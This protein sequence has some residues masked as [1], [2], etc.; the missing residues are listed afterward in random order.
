MF[1]AQRTILMLGSVIATTQT[2]CT[3]NIA[4]FEKIVPN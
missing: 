2:G 3:N 4:E 1:E